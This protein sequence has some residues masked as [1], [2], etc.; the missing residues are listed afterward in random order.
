MIRSHN[1]FVKK[2][3]RAVDISSNLCGISGVKVWDHLIKG[4]PKSPL[5]QWVIYQGMDVCMGIVVSRKSKI[6][7]K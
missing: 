1:L 4:F 7:R 5:K 6:I 2:S 3:F